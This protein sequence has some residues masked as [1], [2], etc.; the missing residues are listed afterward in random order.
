MR[1]DEYGDGKYAP[2]QGACALT[3]AS[4]PYL[5]PKGVYGRNNRVTNSLDMAKQL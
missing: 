4:E 3:D 5:Y 1:Y 2:K